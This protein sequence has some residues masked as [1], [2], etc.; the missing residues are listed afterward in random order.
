VTVTAPAADKADLFRAD[1]SIDSRHDR[2]GGVPS[3][4]TV[5]SVRNRKWA[6]IANPLSLF[7]GKQVKVAKVEP[8]GGFRE[9]GRKTGVNPKKKRGSHI[10]KAAIGSEWDPIGAGT[11]VV[12]SQNSR[13]DRVKGGGEDQGVVNTPTIG[14]HVLV[15]GGY[16]RLRRTGVPN[17]PPEFDS[18]ISHRNW[19]IRGFRSVVRAKSSKAI[20]S[21]GKEK[22]EAGDDVEFSLPHPVG[23]VSGDGVGVEVSARIR[24]WEGDE[25]VS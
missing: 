4:D 23:G 18:D 25:V 5:V 24:G 20:T 19:V 12:R 2:V 21:G 1:Q 6:C 9:A 14:V 15:R 13:T 8:F 10:N 3:K 17:F 16:H 11:G 7:L 22:F